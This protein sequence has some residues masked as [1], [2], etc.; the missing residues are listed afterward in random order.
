MDV[1]LT[2]AV[3]KRVQAN[4]VALLGY[5]L[6]YKGIVLNPCRSKEIYHLQNVQTISGAH[7]VLCADGNMPAFPTLK[8][9]RV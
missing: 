9:T 6:K 4:P 8:M 1:Y 2:S 7:S 3:F 5:W